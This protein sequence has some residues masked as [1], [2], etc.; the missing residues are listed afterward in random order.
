MDENA[1]LTPYD[2]VYRMI[3]EEGRNPGRG[4]E[5][6]KPFCADVRK[7]IS[8]ALRLETIGKKPNYPSD[9]QIKRLVD[10]VR[11]E[12]SRPPGAEKQRKLTAIEI[13][14]E[15]AVQRAL[16]NL[17]IDGGTYLTQEELDQLKQG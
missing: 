4:G 2:V 5:K 15:A 16:D 12:V 11:E 6:W 9:R 13:A 10:Q 3:V 8:K 1:S 14:V 7:A 17:E